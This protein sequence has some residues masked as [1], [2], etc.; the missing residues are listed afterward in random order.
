MNAKTFLLS[1]IWRFFSFKGVITYHSHYGSPCSCLIL[2]L[3]ITFRG[4]RGT[5]RLVLQPVEL[6]E[7]RNLNRSCTRVVSVERTRDNLNRCMYR[8][9]KISTFSRD[10]SC[11]LACHAHS[12]FLLNEIYIKTGEQIRLSV[13]FLCI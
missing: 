5:P 7:G 8:S 12:Q 4:Q 11:L 13:R 2:Y 1:I 3:Q 6:Q 10:V 9:R